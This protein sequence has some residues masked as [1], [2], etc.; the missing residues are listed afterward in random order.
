TQG[1]LSGGVLAWLASAAGQL[2]GSPAGVVRRAQA[3]GAVG[4]RGAVPG[5]RA[6]V[7]AFGPGAGRRPARACGTT[8]GEAWP[9]R[10]PALTAATGASAG[11]AAALRGGSG[12]GRK[13]GVKDRRTVAERGA[14]REVGATPGSRR[15]N[16][17][18]TRCAGG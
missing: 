5:G 9:E 13:G 3:A 2:H 8:G 11:A 15:G 1:G 14:A 7:G 6:V 12:V 17:C 4:P 10:L 18:A 16:R